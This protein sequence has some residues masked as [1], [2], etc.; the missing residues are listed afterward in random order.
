MLVDEPA[1]DREFTYLLPPELASG[2][3]QVTV[4]TVVQVPLHGRSI[5]GWVTKLDAPRPDGV[6]LLAVKRVSGIGPPR[7][8]VDLARWAAWRWA[9]TWAHFMRTA[10]ADRVV[11]GM[12]TAPSRRRDITAGA[13]VSTPDWLRAAWQLDPQTPSIIRLGPCADEWPLMAEALRRGRVLLLVPTVNWAARIAGRLRSEGIPT[14]LMPR[15]WAAAA[16]ALA[17][18]GTRSAVWAP[19][20]QLDTVVVLDEHDEAYQ[21]EAAPTWNARDV[22]VERA[23]RDGAHCLLAGPI[24]SV[25]AVSAARGRSSEPEEVVISAPR[26][27]ARGAWPRVQIADRRGDDPATGEWC[28]EALAEVLRTGRRVVCVLNRTGRARLAYCASCG[29]LARSPDSGRP[30]RLDEQRFVDPDTGEVRPAV[31]E[32]CGTTRFRRARVGVKGVASEL[33]RLTQRAVVQVVGE[34]AR[35]QSGTAGDGPQADLPGGMDTSLYVGTEAVLHRLHSADVVAFLDFDQELM[36][37]RYRAAEEALALLVRAARLV[38][39][40]SAGGRILVQT[41]LPAHP[42]LAA[43][44]DA[45]PTE[46]LRGEIARRVAM[47]QPP[48]AAWALA[49]GAAASTYIERLSAGSY[50]GALDIAG[51]AS[52]T[53]RIRSDEHG[54]LLDALADAERPGGR[55]RVAVDPMRA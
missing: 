5:R 22:A 2:R 30:L 32:S 6:D 55:L 3:V 50:S 53:W 28:G 37:P 46:W 29:E 45:D 39:P 44:A 38:G 42:V 1:I 48:A 34:S 17:V 35:P 10:S 36:A 8:V 24:P 40:R 21:S 13:G 27:S 52:G 11:A 4:G 23:R 16:A 15:D 51:P 49:S 54:T 7:H 33:E 20:G 31:C 41:R 9:G 14:A 12:P 19:C 26:T 43:A 18:V 47:R 25:D